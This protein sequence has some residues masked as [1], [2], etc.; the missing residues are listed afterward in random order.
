MDIQ[1]FKCNEK[2]SFSRP[3]KAIKQMA[4][5]IS[6]GRIPKKLGYYKCRFCEQYHITS[7]M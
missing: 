2:Q 4:S 3:S 6:K 7:V 5:I 1:E